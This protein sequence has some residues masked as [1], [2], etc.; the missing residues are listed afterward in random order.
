MKKITVAVL[1]YQRPEEL[2]SALPVIL[3]HVSALNVESDAFTA[4][5]LI[6]D[7]DPF[8]SAAEVVGSFDPTQ[9]RYVHEPT[10]G[11]SA[12]RNRALD[13]SEDADLLVFIDDDERP[14]E[15]WL[16][17]LLETWLSTGAAAVRGRV[18][19]SF[20]EALDPWIEAGGFFQ[21]PRRPTG[22]VIAAAASGNLLLD[23]VQIREFGVRF[24]NRMGLTGGEDTLFSKQL[25][26][27]G[28]KI[29]WCDESE[30]FDFV[31]IDRATRRWVLQ[32]SWSHGNS[33]TLVEQYLEV[34]TGRILVVRLRGVVGGGGRLVVGIGRFAAG[35]VTGSLKHRARGMRMA[36]YGAG[37]FT[38][39]L[40]H[41]YQE[42]GRAE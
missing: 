32:R 23:L 18:V 12:G 1:T 36:F 19:S 13:A 24:D 20:A 39:A 6:I 29:V 17:P 8:S 42:Y 37:M 22:T 21:R 31:P 7:N 25:T 16:H 26:R 33:A 38:G 9:V 3:R 28:G 35:A 41:V 27:Q 4:S 11:I 2:R 34:D 15:S 10:P 30:A 40:G 14:N 5:V